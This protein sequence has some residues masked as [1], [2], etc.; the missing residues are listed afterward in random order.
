MCTI[1][2]HLPS[3]PRGCRVCGWARNRAAPLRMNAE[4][5]DAL[6]VFC[7]LRRAHR[8]VATLAVM[9]EKSLKASWKMVRD[10]QASRATFVRAVSSGAL[11]PASEVKVLSPVPVS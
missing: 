7:A 11:V 4:S 5:F 8:L 3:L 1:R 9:P 10:L 6:R 2:H